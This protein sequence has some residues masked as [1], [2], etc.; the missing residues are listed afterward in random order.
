MGYTDFSLY[1]YD[2]TNTSPVSNNCEVFY[3]IIWSAYC[4]NALPTYILFSN[5]SIN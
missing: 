3:L 5:F 2:I 4:I 1:N